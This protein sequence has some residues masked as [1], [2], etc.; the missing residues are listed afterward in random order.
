MTAEIAVYNKSGVA[1]AAD[2]AVTISQN[3]SSKIYNG[4]EKLFALTKHHPVGIMVNGS[5][6]LC[7]VPWE[8]IIKEYRKHLGI[9]SF[10]RID[11]Y[12]SDFF[13][14]IEDSN[15]LIPSD[16]RENFLYQLYE[17]ILEQ[18]ANLVESQ[19]EYSEHIENLST[20]PMELIISLFVKVFDAMI[21]GMEKRDFLQNFS[22]EDFSDIMDDIPEILDL[23]I[24][25]YLEDYIQDGMMVTSDFKKKFEQLCCIATTKLIPTIQ[26]AGVIFAGYGD[27][28][29]FPVIKSFNVQGFFHSKV[30]YSIQNSKCVSSPGES[31]I[32]PYAQEEEVASF[33]TGTTP[34]IK[35][36][37]LD[38]IKNSISKIAGH[39]SKELS[40]IGVEPDVQDQFHSDILKI[41][42]E[43]CENIYNNVD[44]WVKR[45]YTQPIVDMVQHL[46]KEEMANMA[47]SLVNL[48]AFRRKVTN[49]QETV[50][51]PIDVAI[52][53]KGDGFIWY[54][55]KHYFQKEL[56]L[57]YFNEIK[58]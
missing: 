16:F 35:N 56:N 43:E 23:I 42:V 29:F 38:E 9:K 12:A 3:E 18:A 39:I 46:P 28:E 32:I 53:S 36:K 49:Q 40:N 33:I 37:F 41:S 26:N 50:G 22:D 47:E 15:L 51:G 54:K 8:M 11:E 34:N 48:S 20:P 31:G 17:E 14:F 1:L 45:E 25:D 4:A 27:K 2:S 24:N 21:S 52:I 57:H 10:D 13:Q 19:S 58:Q 7:G 55:R 5:G 6:A 44:S 30:R